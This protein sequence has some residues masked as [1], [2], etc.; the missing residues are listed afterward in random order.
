MPAAWGMGNLKNVPFAM[1]NTMSFKH[2]KL[3]EAPVGPKLTNAVIQKYMPTHYDSHIALRNLS[4]HSVLGNLINLPNT[5][6]NYTISKPIHSPSST[7]LYS[8]DI[9][10]HTSHEADF[11]KPVTVKC[12]PCRNFYNM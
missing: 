11:E 7:D 1:I 4:E 10:R 2:P 12:T 6:V 9:E 3:T 8:V 5:L